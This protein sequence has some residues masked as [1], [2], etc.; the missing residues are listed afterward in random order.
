MERSWGPGEKLAAQK[1]ILE[2]LL[3]AR[4]GSGIPLL[5]LY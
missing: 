3:T 5:D 4:G 2:V 1:D